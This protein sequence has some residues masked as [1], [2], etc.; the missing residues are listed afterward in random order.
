M[1]DYDPNDPDPEARDD[2]WHDRQHE[3][4]CSECGGK[5]YCRAQ[6]GER[7]TDYACPKCGGKGTVSPP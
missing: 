4:S 7:S 2:G 5:G 3:C 1:K 6:F